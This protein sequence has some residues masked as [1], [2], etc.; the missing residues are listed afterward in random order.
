MSDDNYLVTTEKTL[1]V[2]CTSELKYVTSPDFVKTKI[3]KMGQEKTK[4]YEIKEPTTDLPY[5]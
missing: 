4:V 5:C 2:G 1:V 3:L